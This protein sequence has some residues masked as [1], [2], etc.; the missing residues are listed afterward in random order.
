[1]N[2]P[3]RL[4]LLVAALLLALLGACDDDEGGGRQ[5]TGTDVTGD[6]DVQQDPTQD[7]T[8]DPAA[9]PVQ[10]PTQDP[11]QDPGQDPTPDADAEAD[12][13]DDVAEDLPLD[14]SDVTDETTDVVDE[15]IVEVS[16]IFIN[17]F[18][19]APFANEFVEIYNATDEELSLDGWVIAVTSSTFADPVARSIVAGL[20]IPAGG[21]LALGGVDVSLGSDW[22]ANNGGLIELRDDEGE[23]VDSVLYGA[24]GGAPAPVFN[25]STSRVEDGVSTGDDASDF[26][27]ALAAVHVTRGAA[28]DVPGVALGSSDVTIN[29]IRATASSAAGARNNDFVELL[30]AGGVTVDIAGWSLFHGGSLKI[31]GAE[32]TVPHETEDDEPFFVLGFADFAG[33]YDPST[34]QTTYL[35]NADGVRLQDLVWPGYDSTGAASTGYYPDG[36]DGTLRFD[37]VPS[38]GAPNEIP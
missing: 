12:A 18:G 23:V 3:A 1:M 26:N 34:R 4:S 22:I 15:E 35:F 7:P 24:R 32:T 16:G 30:N 19:S 21:F 31:F 20:T 38:P 8:E 6:Q 10:D 5:D 14:V 27:A 2:R 33:F 13:I 9:D 29:E 37:L 17:E 11:T 25:L 36:L 28:D